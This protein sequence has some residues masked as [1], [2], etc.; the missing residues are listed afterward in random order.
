MKFQSRGELSRAFEKDLKV[1]LKTPLDVV[2]KMAEAYLAYFENSKQIEKPVRTLKVDQIEDDL[3]KRFKVER[4]TFVV[5]SR[6]ILYSAQ[7]FTE[8]DKQDFDKKLAQLNLKDDERN[9]L[10]Q[11]IEIIKDTG[12]M[13]ILFY[14]QELEK[15]VSFGIKRFNSISFI[16]DYRLLDTKD[17]NRTLA[18]IV[19]A[20][21]S[22]IDEDDIE[23]NFAFQLSSTDLD[24]FSRSIEEF[25]L[26]FDREREIINDMTYKG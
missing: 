7:I 23:D 18:P 15:I 10:L 19:I 17:Q 26:K 4:E 3:I 5:I 14:N 13:K 9:D 8:K 6:L 2:S 16:T 12:L 24:Q 25:K 20:K 1:I 11:K 22:F 21:L